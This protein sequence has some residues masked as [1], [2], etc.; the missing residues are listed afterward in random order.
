MVVRVTRVKTST[1]REGAEVEGGAF[2]V[3]GWACGDSFVVAD[4]VAGVAAAEFEGADDDSV[5]GGDAERGGLAVGGVGAH[6]VDV[7]EVPGLVGEW[8]QTGE[9]EDAGAEDVV[10][11]WVGGT[12]ESVAREAGEGLA[13]D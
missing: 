2:V 7:L 4:D 9:P 6:G 12:H 3:G 5:S 11:A 13:D 8:A 1:G 10:A